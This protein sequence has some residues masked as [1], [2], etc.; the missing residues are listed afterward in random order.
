ML[1]LS[2][3][4][5]IISSADNKRFFIYILM[6]QVKSVSCS[7]VSNTF[8]PH[9][10]YPARLLSPWNS[11]GKNTEVGC[12][13]LLQEIFPIQGSNPG[14]PHCRQILYHLSH[15]V[16]KFICAFLF[17]SISYSLGLLVC[18]ELK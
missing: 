7:V 11:P 17:L 12:H 3:Q 8:C 4:F 13:F 14:L 1:F 18:T 15:Q 2:F 16:P 10:L 9:G 6:E 5:M